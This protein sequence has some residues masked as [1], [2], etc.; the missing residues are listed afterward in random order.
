MQRSR[1]IPILVVAVIAALVGLKAL[2]ANASQ[3]APSQLPP[4]VKESN[5]PD[6][7]KAE[8]RPI[9]APSGSWT[10]TLKRLPNESGRLMDMND[11]GDFLYCETP[12]TDYYQDYLFVSNGKPQKLDH[13]AHDVTLLLTEDGKLIKRLPVHTVNGAVG[14]QGGASGATSIYNRGNFIRTTNE[15]G[16]TLNISAGGSPPFTLTQSEDG[17]ISKKLYAANGPIT[18]LDTDKGRIWLRETPKLGAVDQD[19]L[20]LVDNGKAKKIGLPD[21]YHSVSR[22]AATNKYVVATFGR[23]LGKEPFRSYRWDGE[24]WKELPLPKGYQNSYVQK[25]LFDGVVIG[26]I[27]DHDSNVYRQVAWKGESIAI[28][29]NLPGWPQTNHPLVVDRATRNGTLCLK[30]PHSV[31]TTSNEIFLLSLKP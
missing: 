21:G 31:S 11:H 8:N 14:A 15:N 30:D 26:L 27:S 28:L 22:V 29:D 5:Q 3:E 17:G 2:V 18:L 7:P 16:A 10:P 25:V 9:I 1:A 13:N 19:M 4:S 20:V 6:V 24:N 12:S 23:Y